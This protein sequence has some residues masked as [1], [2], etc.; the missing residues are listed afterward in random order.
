MSGPQ[1]SAQ[2]GT[3]RLYLSGDHACSYLEG[4]TARTLLVDPLAAM[5][6]TRYQLLLQRGFRRSG[7]HIY[8]PNCSNCRRCV[9]VRIPVARFFPNRS[10]RR[11][12]ACNNR[13]LVLVERPARFDSEHYTVYER[14][15]HSRHPEGGMSEDAS[16][17]SYYDF[18]IAPWGGETLLLELRQDGHL[19]AVAV[20]DLLPRGLSAVYTFFD[21]IF[22]ERA[23]GTYALLCQ[24]TAARSL[25]L[26]FLY[27]GYWIE[28]CGKMS[29]KARFRPLE[30]LIAGS[31]TRFGRGE[32]ILWADDTPEP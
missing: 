15:L 31:W 7:T 19:V 25:G 3:L 17:E 29:Y 11:N 28:P 27:L 6:G 9:P 23:P 18:L 22:S 8:R 4:L 2:G 13:D 24:I 14:Y 21:P 16:P 1:T 5:D 30:A 20:T 32:P 12:A 10:Q 26:D